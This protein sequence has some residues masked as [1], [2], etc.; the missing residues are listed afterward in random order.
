MKTQKD[1]LYCTLLTIDPL[2]KFTRRGMQR[3]CVNRP[4]SMSQLNNETISK[5][6]YLRM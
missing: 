3:D 5:M 2:M 4:H 6:D 1:V